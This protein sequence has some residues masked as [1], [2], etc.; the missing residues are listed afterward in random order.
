V[1]ADKQKIYETLRFQIIKN[2]LKPGEF[3]NE[4]KLMA[5]FK[6]GRTPLREVFLRLQRDKLI[7]MIPRQ[8]T[9]VTP[10][11]FKDLREIV[12]IRRG[13]EALIGQLAVKRITPT[14][15]IQLKEILKKATNS[16]NKD[17]GCSLM[18]LSRYDMDFHNCILDAI[19]NTRLKE[20]M[21][22]Q[23][24][25]MG[26]LGWQLGLNAEDFFSQFQKLEAVVTALEEKNVEKV[27]A[28][29]LIHLNWYIDKVKNDIL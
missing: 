7:N 25:S 20:M 6:I 19:Q 8:G 21:Y 16:Y 22:E 24:N 13:L 10:I 12:E 27:Q 5:Q 17:N 9:V 23:Q 4:K 1:P 14:H 28:A 26:R 29:L 18:E 2:D 15:I 3:L 11:D